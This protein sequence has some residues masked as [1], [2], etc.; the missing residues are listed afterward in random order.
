MTSNDASSTAAVDGS[1]TEMSPSSSSIGNS[2]TP[3][4]IAADQALARERL[5]LFMA[6][7]AIP[8]LT[9]SRPSGLGQD[10]ATARRNAADA[11]I[12]AFDKAFNKNIEV[13]DKNTGDRG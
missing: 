11:S 10:I 8:V 7:T 6:D 2:K 3:T 12:A 13:D 4:Q 1:A 9:R 5:A